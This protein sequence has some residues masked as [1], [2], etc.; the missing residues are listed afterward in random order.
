MVTTPLQSRKVSVFIN[1]LEAAR[2]QLDTAIRLTF[3]NED[4]LA[5]HTLAAAAYRI[6][7][8][9]LEKQGQHGPDEALRRGMYATALSFARGELSDKEI[10]SIREHKYL[11]ET[12]CNLAKHINAQEAQG[13]ALTLDQVS[14]T[15]DKESK[16]SHWQSISRIDNFLKH[17]NKDLYK[18][19]DLKEVD[20]DTILS[21][22]SNAYT[23][24][25]DHITPEPAA[26]LY[27]SYRNIQ[28]VRRGAAVLEHVKAIKWKAGTGTGQ[29]PVSISRNHR[30]AT[31]ALEQRRAPVARN[32]LPMTTKITLE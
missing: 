25:S 21:Y 12:I 13:V 22:A 16:I 18:L 24:A 14:V 6:L 11:Y 31:I 27:Q 32:I 7:R 10:V 2:R 4:A 28:K 15:S 23:I 17:E 3:S 20:N 8:D 5:I 29:R 1:K 9:I 26:G 30:S 19:I